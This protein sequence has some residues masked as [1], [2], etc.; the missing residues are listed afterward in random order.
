MAR[1][2]V[3]DA[4]QD[5][6]NFS[7]IITDTDEFKAINDKYGHPVGDEVI[8]AL[9][10]RCNQKARKVDFPWTIWRR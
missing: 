6:R 8:C 10:N 2:M 4:I 1:V 7:L 5:H 3:T 9:A